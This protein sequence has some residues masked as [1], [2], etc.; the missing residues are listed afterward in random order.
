VNALFAVLMGMSVLSY[1]KLASSSSTHI[2]LFVTA[3]VIASAAYTAGCAVVRRYGGAL[4]PFWAP[5]AI[6][7]GVLIRLALLPSEP[8][9]SGD[10]YRYMWDGKVQ[11]NGFNPYAYA[12]T[13]SALNGLH[14]PLL[15]RIMDFAKM[16]AIYPPIAE[17][18]FRAAYAMLGE[19]AIGIKVF[20]LLGECISLLLIILILKELKK[21]LVFVAVYALC[22]L[23]IMQ[24]MID[25]HMDA[26]AFPF[27]LLFV[28]FY[29]KRKELPALIGLAASI[30][31]KLLPA[32][33]LLPLAAEEKGAKRLRALILPMLM[34][35]AGYIP[36]LITAGENPFESLSAYSKYWYF[37]GP[38]FDIVLG[39]VGVNEIAHAIVDVLIV[40]WLVYVA[41]GRRPFLEKIYLSFFGFFL[42]SATVHPWYVTWI[43]VMLPF[44]FRWSGVAYVTFINLANIVVIDYKAHGIWHL[45]VGIEILEYAPIIVLFLFELRREKPPALFREDGGG[46]RRSAIEFV[47]KTKE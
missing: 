4:R 42:L 46:I 40:A 44:C 1:L 14:S 10:V 9:A 36:F 23:P 24:F 8:V 43:A 17:W 41:F 37:N 15:P 34:V 30:A 26:I 13:D 39:L 5:V 45:P 25:G 7:V 21:P 12:P 16:R 27:F 2:V 31:A 22:P 18:M 20:L 11:V 28:L 47:R 29:L 33:I 38:V 35:A 6:A 19:R 32:I 3:S